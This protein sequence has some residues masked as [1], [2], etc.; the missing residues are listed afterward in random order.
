[1]VEAH[2]F[3]Y[4]QVESF[5]AEILYHMLDKTQDYD[6]AVVHGSPVQICEEIQLHNLDIC[7]DSVHHEILNALLNVLLV[8]MIPHRPGMKKASLQN[9]I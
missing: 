6:H 5:S 9:G 3:E 1:M 7:M 8:K 2:K 4:E